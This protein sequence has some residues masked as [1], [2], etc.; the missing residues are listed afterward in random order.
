MTNLSDRQT[1]VLKALV[2]EYINT[3][4][5]V[6]SE[7]LEKK[8]NLGVSPATI[9]N[10]LSDLTQQGYLK[11]PHTSAGRVPTPMGLKFYISNLMQQQDLSVVDE[12]YDKEKIWD[13]RFDTDRLLQKA[14]LALANRTKTLAVAATDEGDVYYSGTSHILDM[15]EFFDIDLTRH[16]LE[17]LDEFKQ[18]QDL[19]FNRVNPDE[20]VHVVMGDDLNWPYMDPVGFV[21]SNFNAGKVHGSIGIIGPC[22]L[23]YPYVI[24]TVRYFSGLISDIGKGW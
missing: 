20:E 8:Y 3:A 23:N 2:E 21:F 16:V 6:S 11:Q 4:E 1:K 14:A 15:P 5:P 10:E 24:P 12:V 7:L 22:R 18:L 13:Y 17:L 19:F 9:R